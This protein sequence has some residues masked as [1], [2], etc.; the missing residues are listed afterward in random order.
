MNLNDLRS[1]ILFGLGTLGT[2]MLIAVLLLAASTAHG[3]TVPAEQFSFENQENPYDTS[4]YQYS[5]AR[6]YIPLER[7]SLIDNLIRTRENC[8]KYI[9]VLEQFVSCSSGLFDTD[10]VSESNDSDQN[11]STNVGQSS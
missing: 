2:G 1:H 5:F 7:S 6:D 8:P 9:S 4:S 3:A 11:R 10:L